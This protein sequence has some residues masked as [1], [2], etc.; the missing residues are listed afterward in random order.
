MQYAQEKTTAFLS[1]FLLVWPGKQLLVSGLL[2]TSL[3]VS[4]RVLH[5]NLLVHLEQILQNTFF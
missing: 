1:L 5:C 3:N 4:V 2:L